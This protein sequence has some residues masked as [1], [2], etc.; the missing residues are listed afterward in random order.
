MIVLVSDRII[1]GLNGQ[2]I[3][4]CV[5]EAYL[6][7]PEHAATVLCRLAQARVSQDDITAVVIEIED[8]ED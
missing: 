6:R 7:S 1:K 2:E 3:A 4:A 5:E 8:L